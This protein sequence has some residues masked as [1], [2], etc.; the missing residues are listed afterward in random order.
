MPKELVFED[1]TKEELEFISNGCGGPFPVPAFVFEGDCDRHD[2]DYYVGCTEEDR[3]EADLRYFRLMRDSANKAKWW[4]RP[5]YH[6]MAIKYFLFVRHAGYPFFY[7]ADRKKTY[8]D[9][10]EEMAMN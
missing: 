4:K 9:V 5:W 3:L 8:E 6:A 10:R 2:F 1:L 7:R